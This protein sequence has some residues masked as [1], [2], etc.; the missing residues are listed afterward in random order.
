M[1]AEAKRNAV[2]GRLP[3]FV[4][5][6]CLALASP[7]GSAADGWPTVHQATASVARAE[8]RGDALLKIAA[9]A[10][11]EQ[12]VLPGDPVAAA[13]GLE[14]D[15]AWLK[16]LV[17][18]YGLRA[19]YAPALDPAAWFVRQK[20]SEHQ[21][22]T[23]PLLTLSRPAG[24]AILAQV[25]NRTDERLAAAVLPDLLWH[26]EPRVPVLWQS[27]LERLGGDDA[28]A[29][30]LASIRDEWFA[31][32]SPPA[33]TEDS[34]AAAKVVGNGIESLAT[35]VGAAVMAGPPDALRLERLR[36]GLL[37]A[38][39]DLAESE[40]LDMTTLLRLAALIDGLQDGRYLPFSAGLLFLVA[41]MLEHAIAAP[42]NAQPLPR[43]L[44]EQLPALSNAYAR[45]FADVDP[46]LNSALAAA[47]DVL[48]HLV[49]EGAQPLNT[50]ALREELA[51]AAAQLS[52]MIPDPD[53]YFDQPVR[54]TV[55]G[56]VDACLGIIA[57]RNPDGSSAVTREVYD[58]CQQSL[59][60]L[61]DGEIRGPALSGDPDGP[62]GAVELD[63]ELDLIPVQRINYGLGYLHQRYAAGCETPAEALPNPLEWAALANLMVW[64][65]EQSPVYFQTPEN[66]QRLLDML[67]I[68]SQLVQVLAEQVDC[69]AG[70]GAGVND[71]ISR[72][73]VD[74]QLALTQMGAG[75]VEAIAEARA[76]LLAPGADVR[77]ERDASQSTAYRPDDLLIGPCD[78]A[79]YCEMNGKLSSTRA[80]WGLF[81]DEYLLADQSRLGTIAICYTNM[82]WVQ[83]RSEPVRADDPHVANYFG[84]LSFDLLG[85]YLD[86]GGVTTVFGFRF[87]SPEEHHYLFAGADE[88]VLEDSCPTER[89]GSRIVT[90]MRESRG[91]IVPNRLTYLAAG[92]AVPSRLLAAHWDRGAEWRDWFITGIGVEALDLPL[93]RD[94]GPEVTQHLQSLQRTE[95]AAVYHS[96]IDP[97]EEGLLPGMR[98]RFDLTRELTT[99][100]ALLRMQLSL[101][102]P[103]ESLYAEG[104]RRAIE[105]QGG[106]VDAAILARLRQADAAVDSIAE[107]SFGRLDAFR[108]QWQRLPE[109]VRRTGS[110][111]ASVAHAMMRLHA[112]YEQFFGAR[113]PSQGNWPFSPA[114]VG[115]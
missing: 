54:D 25:F 104:I 107:M 69:L 65:A 66:E 3:G 36:V 51:D 98:S 28:L 92:R 80:L 96:L 40:H 50:A 35:L 85:T 77:L 8:T 23:S 38:A 99:R 86:G 114:A 58:D 7:P 93:P 33:K 61:A 102:Y 103:Q 15:L 110:V 1:T 5:L 45:A 64:F 113:P 39:P 29:S 88:E 21:L 18:R 97:L 75:L 46:R 108:T 34:T 87:T 100:K 115:G 17:S 73:L 76:H 4:L 94:I 19:P 70:A 12:Q 78:P 13:R 55:A 22:P 47:Y 2:R 74:Y 57:Q 42:E 84:H 6:A 71:A 82:E 48:T 109:A 101:L 72:G 37:S 62:F 63:R 79:Q 44:A 83:R 20:L 24:K 30:A 11:F 111:P 9:A 59:L 81:P 14:Q 105:G 16:R 49:R 60:G 43:A 10:H 56:S 52:L 31:D 32:W 53:Y 27:M 89:V 68:G 26:L 112:I 106:L 95:Q 91:G 41:D 67:E 90:P